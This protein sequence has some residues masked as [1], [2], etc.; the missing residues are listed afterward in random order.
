MADIEPMLTMLPPPWS[1]IFRPNAWQQFQTPS[2]LTS[3]T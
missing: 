1:A 2:T 3:M